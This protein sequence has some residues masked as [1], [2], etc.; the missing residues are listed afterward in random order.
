MIAG[1][2]IRI[3]VTFV[4]LLVW[5]ALSSKVAGLGPTAT[6]LG[7]ALVLVVFAIIVI[8]ELG[9]ALVA[10]R[11]G[12]RTREIL[13]LPI[14]GIANLE[15]I[16]ERPSQ[17]LAIAVVGPAINLVL[18]GVIW[19]AIALAGG[20]VHLGDATS[21][22]GLFAAQLLWINVALALFNLIPAFPMDGGRAL[23][24]LLAMRLG[25]E[26]ATE[27]A[28]GLGK[29]F[30]VTLGVYGLLT[31]PWLVLIALVIWFGARHEGEITRLRSAI[32]DVPVS[33]AMNRQVHTVTPDES[34][35]EAARWLVASGQSQVPIVDHGAPVGVLTRGDVATGLARAGASS[36]VAAA[37]HHDAFIVTPAD[38]LVDVFDQLAQSPETVAVVVQDGMPVGIVSPEQIA[39]FVALRERPIAPH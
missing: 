1:I 33:A 23:R 26:R 9:H 16:P 10:R 19:F 12:V 5:V 24:A 8:H 30:A 27:I 3:H 15:R 38:R 17:E 36:P 31:S 13:L 18:A 28:A 34:L 32:R 35:E 39:S 20:D 11:Y 7:V 4:L 22:G 25:R 14:G 37:P 21:L 6:L 29:M 2:Q